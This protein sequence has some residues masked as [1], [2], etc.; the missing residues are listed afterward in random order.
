MHIFLLSMI[1]IFFC[2][3]TNKKGVPLFVRSVFAWATIVL[4]LTVVVQEEP[5]DYILKL[6]R[7]E[8]H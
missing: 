3:A 8:I 4:R 5:R 7:S 1:N 2:F 6:T